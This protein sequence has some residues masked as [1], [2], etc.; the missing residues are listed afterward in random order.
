MNREDV[1][2]KKFVHFI[3][4]KYKNQDKVKINCFACSDGSEPYSLAIHLINELG[5]QKAKKFLPI[6]ASDISE[7]VINEAKTGKILLH[8]KTL[9]LL[10]IQIHQIVS[11]EIIQNLSKILETLNFIL[12]R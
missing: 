10:I 9:I 4:K 6:E 1:D 2:W 5:I 3:D 7:P 8:K 12:I 11:K